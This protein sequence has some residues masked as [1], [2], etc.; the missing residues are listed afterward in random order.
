MK[1]R[2]RQEWDSNIRRQ[3]RRATDDAIVAIDS[4]ADTSEK[5]PVMNHA[6]RTVDRLRRLR[7]KLGPRNPLEDPR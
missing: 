3:V 6:A 2:G 4:L 5:D 7:T 1:P